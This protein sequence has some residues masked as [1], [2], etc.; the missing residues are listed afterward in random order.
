MMN[1][2]RNRGEQGIGEEIGQLQAERNKYKIAL[3][4]LAKLGNEPHLGNSIGNK[5]AQQALNET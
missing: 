4:K 3:E 5:I 1:C 2:I